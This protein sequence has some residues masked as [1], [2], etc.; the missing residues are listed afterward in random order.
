MIVSK[1]DFK[2]GVL[3]KFHD[4]NFYGLDTETTG[5][6]WWE[7]D[8][9]F[10]IILANESDSYYFNFK[11]TPDHLGNLCPDEYTLPLSWLQDFNPVFNNKDSTWFVHNVKFDLGMLAREGFHLG[12]T[13]HCTEAM[14]RLI[15]SQHYSYSLKECLKRK[16][17][18]LGIKGAQKSDAVDEYIKE[19]KLYDEILIPGKKKKI[20]NKKFYL[21]PFDVMSKYGV[22]DGRAVYDLG[23]YQRDQ[24]NNNLRLKHP[25][26]IHVAINERNLSPVLFNMEKKGVTVDS[27]YL[28]KSIELDTKASKKLKLDYEGYTGKPFV[29]SNVQFSKYFDQEGIDYPLSEKGNPSFAKGVLKDIE[30]PISQIIL[31]IRAADK[32][33]SS[34]FTNFE[35]YTS[36][37][38][39]KIHANIKQGGT[40]TGRMSV[41]DPALQTI[42]KLEKDI[43]DEQDDDVNS[44]MVRSCFIPYS[45]DYCLF[46]PD[47]DQMEYRM[48]VDQAEEMELIEAIKSGLD[49]HSA[50]AELVNC[51][52][53]AAK[54]INF[55][56]LY[57]GGTQKLADALGI[58]YNE[59]K[60]L[61]Q[62][63]FMKLK[64]VKKWINLTIKKAEIRGYCVNWMGRIC[65]LDRKYAYKAPNYE[66]QGGSSD[67]VKLSMVKIDNMLK[68]YKTDM[69]LQIHDELMFNLHKDELHL[70]PKI[71]D[72]ME[73]TYPHKHLKLTAGASFSMNNWGEKIDGYPTRNEFQKARV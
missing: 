10:S 71:V 58:S 12:G 30:H 40:Q 21:V 59:A 42:P 43:D 20:K 48:M 45:N 65:S 47:F 61:K 49:V 17:L 57:G 29:D 26:I 18:S 23:Q 50:T 69:N 37:T 11:T 60:E 64:N 39:N 52:R 73:N 51:T 72:I 19:H 68:E 62:R 4:A 14:A 70:A 25:E 24:I 6:R 15:N 2:N 8:R 56:L 44:A 32:R 16:D 54:T 9:L 5:L 63:Y 35:Y 41:R 28:Q 36:E 38:D 3:E 1:S 31:D 53:K 34:Y 13:T 55:L 22:D 66:I 27:E 33:L 46:L 67:L 7:N